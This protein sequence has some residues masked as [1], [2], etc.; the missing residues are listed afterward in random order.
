MS[1]FVTVGNALQPFSR[2]LDA[3]GAIAGTLPQPV[4]VQHG[5]TPF[6]NSHCDAVA[7]MAMTRFEHAM[8][9]SRLVITHAGAGSMIHA[10]QAGRKPVVMPRQQEF[11]EHIDNHQSELAGAFA[12]IGRI[13]MVTDPAQLAAAVQELLRA[14]P[15]TI[16]GPAAPM[17]RLLGERL[18][19]YGARFTLDL[20]PNA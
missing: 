19:S 2:L 6:H 9:T 11:G 5:H 1:T 8:S 7:F 14:Q 18:A 13:V 20:R 15:G 10:L 17:T 4:L 16:G 12:S 3:V